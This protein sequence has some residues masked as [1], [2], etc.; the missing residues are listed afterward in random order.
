[1]ATNMVRAP[2][3]PQLTISTTQKTLVDNANY[4]DATLI[5]LHIARWL[6]TQGV[7]YAFQM[8]DAVVCFFPDKRLLYWHTKATRIFLN[9]SALSHWIVEERLAIHRHQVEDI[10]QPLFTW[11]HRFPRLRARECNGPN[12]V[13]WNQ[14]EN[15][16]CIRFCY[17]NIDDLTVATAATAAATQNV[18]IHRII[19]RRCHHRLLLRCFALHDKALGGC[20]PVHRLTETATHDLGH[21]K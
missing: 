3:R 4:E 11:V 10:Y 19:R 13:N 2:Q 14:R 6:L 12:F 9:G 18:V 21:R 5:M 16:H 17:L 20:S 8:I 7:H 1:M 15:G